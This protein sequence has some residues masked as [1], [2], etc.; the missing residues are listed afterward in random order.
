MIGVAY[1]KRASLSVWIVI[2]AISGLLWACGA[3]GYSCPEDSYLENGV[4][5]EAC[6][7]G[8]ILIDGHC[9]SSSDL[10]SDGDDPVDG[11]VGDGDAEDGD[12]NDNC[13]PDSCK[14]H[15]LCDS[16]DGSCTCDNEYMTLDCGACDTGYTG[17]PDC[18]SSGFPGGFPKS[19]CEHRQC[20][21][22]PPTRQTACYRWDGSQGETDCAGG[23]PASCGEDPPLSG[24]GQ[25]A[26]YAN[27]K[28]TITCYNA[29]GSAMPC[30]TLTA[31]QPTKNT[32]VT[33]SLTGLMWQRAMVMKKWREA[34]EYCEE[35]TYAGRSDWR[36]PNPHEL[37]S[38]V[39]DGKHDLAL[40]EAAFP[41]TPEHCW[42]SSENVE[43]RED[44][45]VVTFSEGIL[46]TSFTES[47]SCVRCV[48]G[49][50]EASDSRSLNRFL[51]TETEENVVTDI[52]TKLIWQVSDLSGKTWE[53]ALA[54]CEGLTYAEESEWRLPN[55]KELI[56]LLHYGN[57]LYN[58]STDF[59]DNV[60]S[61]FWSSTSSV[62][63]SGSA[64]IANFWTGQVDMS[65]KWDTNAV[66]CVHNEE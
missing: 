55:K 5:I 15:G 10:F 29:M 50:P 53:E 7:D 60:A 40:D 58:V 17:Y 13:N 26:Q 39:D 61:V 11:D 38:I 27:H 51:F 4:C 32:V 23:I 20:W 12:E 34:L 3:D 6:P 22:V 36:L 19:Y 65:S 41:D 66:L 35:L 28:T 24:C 2:L 21:L 62:K 59:P 47:P 44:A 49:G 14:G 16:M 25:D 64:W 54:H 9:E 33:D 1:T 46:S 56:S 63:D 31:H 8:Q 57:R 30:D 45:W 48:R 52:V 18:V 42:T 37:Q 43:A